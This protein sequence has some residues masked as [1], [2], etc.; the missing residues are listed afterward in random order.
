[1][2]K[3]DGALP[4]FALLPLLLELYVHVDSRKMQPATELLAATAVD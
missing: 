3:V 2:L 1:V 4:A